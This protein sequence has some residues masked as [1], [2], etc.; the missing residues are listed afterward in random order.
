MVL[1]LVIPHIMV[2]ITLI[3]TDKFSYFQNQNYSAFHFISA[4]YSDDILNAYY[5]NKKKISNIKNLAI[6]CMAAMRVRYVGLIRFIQ[7][8]LMCACAPSFTKIV[9]KLRDYFVL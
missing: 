2:R 9:L 3:G 4:D 7:T 5:I 8:Y 6:L 1:V